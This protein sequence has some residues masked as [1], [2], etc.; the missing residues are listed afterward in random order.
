MALPVCSDLRIFST[1]LGNPLQAG[2]STLGSFSTHDKN[3][4]NLIP[5]GMVKGTSFGSSD[6]YKG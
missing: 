2:L 3:C 6:L 5:S 4:E 1:L